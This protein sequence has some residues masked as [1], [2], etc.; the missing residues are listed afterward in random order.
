MAGSG[1]DAASARMCK[2]FRGSSSLFSLL[3]KLHLS[4]SFVLEA[5]T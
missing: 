1:K 4:C 2:H 3:Y 5:Q